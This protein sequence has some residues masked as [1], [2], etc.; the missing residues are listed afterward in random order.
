[1]LPLRRRR[2]HAA[3][4]HL[5]EDAVV[6]EEREEVGHLALTQPE[7]GGGLAALRRLLAHHNRDALIAAIMRAQQLERVLVRLIVAD[8]DG[9]DALV[10][11]GGA[12]R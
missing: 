10:A 3:I 8:V 11:L 12:A 7:L 6:Q 1:M 9:Y 5:D 4:G 2:A